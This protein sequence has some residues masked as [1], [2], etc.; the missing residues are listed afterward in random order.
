MLEPHAISNFVHCEL[1]NYK[2]EINTN[3]DIDSSV[4]D[5]GCLSRIRPFLVIP[6]PDPESYIKKRGAK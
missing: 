5:P 3:Y 4:A 1:V 2:F 6:D